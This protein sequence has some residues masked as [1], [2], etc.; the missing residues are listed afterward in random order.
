VKKWH[1]LI[2]FYFG[3]YCLVLLKLKTKIDVLNK[4]SIDYK[5]NDCQ[6][7][8]YIQEDVLKLINDV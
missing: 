8:F 3:E 4:L 2:L 5:Y 7:D 1:F 6:F